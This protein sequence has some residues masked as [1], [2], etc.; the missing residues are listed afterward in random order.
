MTH[1]SIFTG[2]FQPLVDVVFIEVCSVNVIQIKG[3]SLRDAVL[4]HVDGLVSVL[5]LDELQQFSESKGSDLQPG[6]ARLNP[7]AVMGA[8]GQWFRY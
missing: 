4:G 8:P 5:I 2:T 6:R 7:G 1:E 3:S